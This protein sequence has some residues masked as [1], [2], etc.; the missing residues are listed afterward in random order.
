MSLSYEAWRITFQSSEQAAR[1]AYQAA[2][3]HAAECDALA[4]HVD[5]LTDLLKEHHGD[6]IGDGSE[7]WDEEDWDG[8]VAFALEDTPEI[9]LAQRDEQ[10]RDHTSRCQTA[11]C[12]AMLARQNDLTMVEEILIAAGMTE[13]SDF[14]GCTE[15]DIDEIAA[16]Q[17][18]RIRVIEVQTDAG[19]D[20]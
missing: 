13:P 4:A 10:I 5:R 17:P 7:S 3:K 18:R 20:E 11:A 8:R 6:F 15:E 16:L 2:T 12:C 19:A 9:S 14:I 1:A